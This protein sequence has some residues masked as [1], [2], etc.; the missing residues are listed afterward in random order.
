MEKIEVIEPLMIRFIFH[1]F[2][3][4]YLLPIT[5]AVVFHLYFSA[6]FFFHIENEINARCD[7]T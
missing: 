6:A 2:R 1:L 7:F 3:L 5:T 4:L